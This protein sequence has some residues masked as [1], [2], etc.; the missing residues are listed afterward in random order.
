MVVTAT[1]IKEKEYDCK[2]GGEDVQLVNLSDMPTPAYEIWSYVFDWS[3]NQYAQKNSLL[4]FLTGVLSSTMLEIVPPTMEQ[5]M[6]GGGIKGNINSFA[7]KSASSIAKTPIGRRGNPLNV[8]SGTNAPATIGGRQFT[9]HALDQMQSRGIMPSVVEN[10]IQQGTKSAGN[11]VGTTVH[12][13]EN[14][15]IVTNQAGEVITVIPK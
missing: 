13:F 9:G 4:P 3:V 8:I 6:M 12:S 14:V 7:A 11:T 2:W 15:K 1:K 10:A 5:M